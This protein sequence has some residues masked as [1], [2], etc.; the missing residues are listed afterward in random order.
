MAE[1][2]LFLIFIEICSFEGENRYEIMFSF[3]YNFKC[4]RGELKLVTYL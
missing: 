1:R 4:N 3:C 2:S